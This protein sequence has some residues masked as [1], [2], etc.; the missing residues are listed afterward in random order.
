MPAS[1]RVSP[2]DRVRGQI[3]ELF[4]SGRELGQILEEVARLGVKLLLQVVM[5][6]EL[7][8]A[9]STSSNL[10][11]WRTGAAGSASAIPRATSGTSRGP[12]AP[13]STTR[14][15][16]FSLTGYLSPEL[17]WL[18]DLMLLIRR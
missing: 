2:V 13:A 7:T 3:D 10:P 14:A 16:S 15:A 4:G 11:S 8:D 12:R 5:E 1:K 18:R 6:A 9:T 17:L